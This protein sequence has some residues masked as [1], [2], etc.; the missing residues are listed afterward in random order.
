MPPP[1]RILHLSSARTWR[2][3]EQQLAYLIGELDKAGYRQWVGCARGSAMEA[4]CVE[5][6]I[7]HFSYRKGFSLNPLAGFALWRR[8]RKLK[9]DILHTHDSHAHTLALLSVLWGNRTPLVVHR[10]V[11]FPVGGHFFSRWKYN[12][13]LVKKI[14]CT[15]AGIR[16]VTAPAIRDAAKLTVVHSGIDLARFGLTAAGKPLSP[17]L[18]SDF[19]RRKFHLPEG[20]FIIA[21]L[22]AL[23]PHKDYPTFV[24]TA[25]LLVKEGIPARFFAIG[26]DGGEEAAVRRLVREKGLEGHFIFT[27]QRSDVPHLLPGIDLLLFTSKT[28]GIGGALLEAFACRVPVVA[29]AAGGIPEIVKDGTTGLLARPGDASSLAQLAARVLHDP[30]LRQRLTDQAFETALRFTKEKTG[31]G[32]RRVYDGLVPA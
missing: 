28:E 4:Y 29:T 10:R 23:A 31:E 2:G 11:D 21:N 26:G 24:R 22:A 18:S 15:S 5:K 3:G 30:G 9:P 20:H 17:T 13:P 1:H 16:D 19:L 27:G 32:V 8:C 25:E 7:A 12:H 14:I 6:G